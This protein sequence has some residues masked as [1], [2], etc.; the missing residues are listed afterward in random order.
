MDDLY[1]GLWC[2][3]GCEVT[4]DI[5]FTTGM[6]PP[7]FL[8][9]SHLT[10]EWRIPWSPILTVLEDISVMS[11]RVPVTRWHSYWGRYV[12]LAPTWTVLNPV[13]LDGAGLVVVS[14]VYNYDFISSDHYDAAYSNCRI[15]LLLQ[16]GDRAG[17]HVVCL[18]PMEGVDDDDQVWWVCWNISICD[19]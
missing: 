1:A 15:L 4:S 10:H 19:Y 8:P 17:H 18:G 12:R 6:L 13:T 11:C 7:S 14:R 2:V 9:P 5:I 3:W 16:S